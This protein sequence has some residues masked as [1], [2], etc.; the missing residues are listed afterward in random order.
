MSRGGGVGH[1]PLHKISVRWWAS[2]VLFFELVSSFENK[3]NGKD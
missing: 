3:G 1:Q 2:P